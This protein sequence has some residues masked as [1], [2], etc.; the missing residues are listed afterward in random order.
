[1]I[2]NEG[3]G[4]YARL[5]S[6]FAIRHLTI[7]NR[8]M[9]TAHA[10][11][12]TRDG[13][14]S[15][16]DAE[17]YRERARG[18]VGLFVVGNFIVH[19]TG[20][21]GRRG[22][23]YTFL[24]EAEAGLRRV[25][26][27][28]HEE[29]AR[30]ILQINHFGGSV[31]SDPDDYRVLWSPSGGV[32]PISGEHAQAME[33]EDIAATIRAFAEAA[34][35]AQRAGVDGIELHMAH[36]YLLNSF[37][38]PFSNQRTDDYG[39]SLANRMRLPLEVLSAVRDS[40]GPDFVVGFRLSLSDELPGGLT[41]DDACAI[42]QI[43]QETKSVDFLT[44]TAGGGPMFWVAAQTGF[45]PDGYLLDK[46]KTL[47]AETALP[48]FA[49]GGIDDPDLAERV[50]AENSADM[51]A[52]TR[53]Q[54]AD[55][56]FARK[57]KEGRSDEIRHCIRGNQGCLSRVARGMPMTCTV[58]PAAGREGLFGSGKQSRAEVPKRW[59]VV[60][61]G[62][63]GMKAAEVLAER[64]HAVTL[65]EREP[66]LGGQL[67]FIRQLPGRSQWDYIRTDLM[68]SM[69]R[70]GVDIR[71]GVSATA[72]FV[73]SFGADQVLIATGASPD[74]TGASCSAPPPPGLETIR[75]LTLWEAIANPEQAGRRAVLLDDE[76]A[77]RIGGAAQLMLDAGC[78][79]I[80]V[81]RLPMLLPATVYTL[82]LPQLY[83]NLLGK[84][85]RYH[86]NSWIRNVGGDCVTIGTPF[87]PDAE[88]L[89]GIDSIVLG[90]PRHPDDALYRA[91]KP[92]LSGL[93]R[94]GDCVAPRTMDHAIYEGFLAGQEMLDWSDRP[95]FEDGRD[96]SLPIKLA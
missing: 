62:P 54:I 52:I 58:N 45:A 7:R 66:E 60:G 70:L 67:R 93:A 48:V 47:K 28:I 17:Y 59:L 8:L 13:V 91:L 86:L 22:I 87:S 44:C 73:E 95:F 30:I 82:D 77:F 72:E 9:Q 34:A 36:G 78:E 18:G 27:I 50:L 40:V 85:L 96:P 49:V 43:L 94:V 33:A 46:V 83:R 14:L 68:R 38:S 55:P 12:F 21:P 64:G 6:P 56:E 42:A 51:I 39:G 15:D 5:L 23:S 76:G 16:R 24:P 79:V 88:R 80:L 63:A 11:H 61:G 20:G 75:T 1:M 92:G 37:L 71:L 74:R 25:A 65:V 89:T 41:I 3:R 19:P 69:E 29:D 2:R 32:S 90:T 57:V 84:G 4:R 31:T 81:S 35:M 26:E 10:Q 53:G